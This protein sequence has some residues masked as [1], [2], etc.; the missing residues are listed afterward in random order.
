M[1]KRV[2]LWISAVFVLLIATAIIWYVAT[3]TKGPALIFVRYVQ[4]PMSQAWCAELLLTNVTRDYIIVQP[5]YVNGYIFPAC[6]YQ[7]QPSNRWMFAATKKGPIPS[8]IGM[9]PNW[10]SPSE[11]FVAAGGPSSLRFL[12]VPGASPKRIGIEYQIKDAFK[13][14]ILQTISSWLD[15]LRQRVGIRAGWRI[16]EVW[17]P[18]LLSLPPGGAVTNTPATTPP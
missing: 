8:S 1:K 3:P 6:L 14:R 9:G 18:E 13:S 16:H 2:L 12:V 11:W 4:L 17:C 15:R 5:A 7:E 10:G